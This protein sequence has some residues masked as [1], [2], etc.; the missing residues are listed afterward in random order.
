M[1][2]AI[3][4][5]ILIFTFG[6]ALLALGCASKPP[7]ETGFL[8]DYSKLQPSPYADAEGALSYVDPGKS[9]GEYDQFILEPVQI[10]LSE[11]AAKRALDPTKLKEMADYFNEQLA[12]ELA[13]SDYAIVSQPAPKTLRFRGALTDVEP[14]MIAANLYPATMISGVGLGGASMEAEFLDSQSGEVV[15]AVVDSQKGE[16]GFDGLT[17]YGNAENVIQRWAKRLVIRMDEAHGKSR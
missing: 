13:A 7:A 3:R 1:N 4:T 6:A 2:S 11:E 16:R 5:S 12:A 8:S 9:L 10:S 17:K 15:A 14:A